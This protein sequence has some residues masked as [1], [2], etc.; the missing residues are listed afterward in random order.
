MSPTAYSRDVNE[1]TIG[2]HGTS[3]PTVVLWHADDH[4]GSGGSATLDQLVAALSARGRRVVVPSWRV[5]HARIDLLTSLRVARE[6][7]DHPPDQTTVVGFESA[8]LA[9][10]SLVAHQRR[11]GVT[12]ERA[13]CIDVGA[14]TGLDPVTGQRLGAPPQRRAEQST[15][16][17]FVHCQ[18]DRRFAAGDVHGA[19]DLW[20]HRGW[21]VELHEIAVPRSALLGE[22]VDQ[23]ADVITTPPSPAA[24]PT[25]S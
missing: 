5:E 9:A 7:A 6:S 18:D 20:R 25:G 23:L 21:P 16:T 11:L 10:A 17:A 1:A 19:A 13:V 4:L 3:G 2:V 15:S 22:G 14:L 24:G 8:G 12:I